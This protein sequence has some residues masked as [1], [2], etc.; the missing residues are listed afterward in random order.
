MSL[1]IDGVDELVSV[2]SAG[3]GDSSGLLAPGG[4]VGGVAVSTAASVDS[5]EDEEN[6]MVS[7]NEI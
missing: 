2:V 3:P 6:G 4:V 5:T 7:S 1:S